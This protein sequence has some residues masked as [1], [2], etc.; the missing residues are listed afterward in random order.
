MT[1]RLARFFTA[2]LFCCVAGSTRAALP[3]IDLFG[4][5]GVPGSSGY[6]T[7]MGPCYC[8]QTMYSSPVMLLQPGTYDFG[9]LKAYWVPSGY[10]PDGGPDQPILWLLFAPVE[11]TADYPYTYTGLPTYAYPSYALCAQDDAACN[12][13]YDGAFVDFDLVYTVPSGDDAIQIGLIA[14]YL[15]TA[16][17][18]EPSTLVLAVLGAMLVAASARL[19]R[20]ARARRFGPG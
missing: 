15:Y 12:A 16:P 14:K 11:V 17:V 3:A 2:V 13:S 1:T 20:R 7:I 19:R 4:A 5:D 6:S 8:D 10:T 18:P 9:R